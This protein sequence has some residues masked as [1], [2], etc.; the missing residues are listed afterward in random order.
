MK[1][2]MEEIIGDTSHE[3]EYCKMLCRQWW[4][5]VIDHLSR[6]QFTCLQIIIS[7]FLSHSCLPPCVPFSLS[8]SFLPLLFLLFILLPL[9]IVKLL[10]DAY[11]STSHCAIF[12]YTSTYTC[13]H[14]SYWIDIR[15]LIKQLK[16]FNANEI[17]ILLIFFRII[18]RFLCGNNSIATNY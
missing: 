17:L 4:Y 1:L 14:V 18:N 15:C 11:I 5:Y 8:L 16:N 6:Y 10:M 13:R 2:C 9:L 12:M 7:Y 3:F